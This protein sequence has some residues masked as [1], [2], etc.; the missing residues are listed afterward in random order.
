MPPFSGAEDPVVIGFDSDGSVTS[1]TSNEGTTKN[2]G[3][4]PSEGKLVVENYSGFYPCGGFDMS[5]IFCSVPNPAITVFK[6]RTCHKCGQNCGTFEGYQK[7]CIVQKKIGEGSGFVETEV[8]FHE[9]CLRIHIWRIDH[10]N[11]F[12]P[13]LQDLLKY[14]HSVHIIARFV[15]RACE[16][17]RA[18][19]L[20]GS[21]AA[22]PLKEGEKKKG[23]K[24]IFSFL[25]KKKKNAITPS[26][27]I[28]DDSPE[29]QVDESA[30]SPNIRSSEM[31]ENVS[32][33][34]MNQITESDMKEV[35]KKPETKRMNPGVRWMKV[36]TKEKAQALGM[37]VGSSEQP[38]VL[39]AIKFNNFDK[40]KIPKST[41]W[42]R[43]YEI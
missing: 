25:S 16:R 34:K 22:V 21:E 18:K 13:V 12:R 23:T 14:F 2:V 31:A 32:K 43:K 11:A 41:F 26:S 28:F 9:W 4:N 7:K 10:S 6:A 27:K 1:K 40:T 36:G 15:R 8:Y 29:E 39:D 35:E 37:S 30:D 20:E 5:W 38:P 3:E 33:E 19:A 17:R 24:R 42:N